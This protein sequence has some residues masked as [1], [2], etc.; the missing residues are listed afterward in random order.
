M[1]EPLRRPDD[2]ASRHLIE[3]AWN[4]PDLLMMLDFAG[5]ILVINPAWTDTLDRDAGSLVGQTFL[6]FVHVD[7]VERT[8]R[9]WDD[10]HDGVQVVDERNRWQDSNGVW[11]WLSWSLHRDVDARRVYAAGRDVTNM[12]TQFLRVTHDR[13]LLEAAE[14][15]AAVGS[16]EWDLGAGVVALS[17]E[18]RQLLHLNGDDEPIRAQRLLAQVHPDDRSTVFAQMEHARSGGVPVQF[19]F[20]IPDG[21]GS[22]RILLARAEPYHEDGHVAR[23]YGAVQ[24]ITDQRR[25]DRLKDAFLA[26]VSH[27]L[28]TPLTVVQGIAATLQRIESLNTATRRRLQDA[29]E[30]NVARLSELMTDL[31]DL[32]Q[33]G[34]EQMQFR[35]AV[36]DLVE[37][38]TEVA[39]AATDAARIVVEGPPQL[40]VVANR[41]MVERIL[42]NL[43]DNAGKYAPSGPVTVSIARLHRDGFQLTVADEG[44]GIPEPERE[45]IFQPFH[46]LADE[47][48]QPGTG[49]GLTLVA[50]FVQAHEGRVYARPRDG[51]AELVVEIP[52]TS[53]ITPPHRPRQ[54]S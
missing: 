3:L 54:G 52:G 1:M 7:D 35:P 32:A 53:E 39:S 6:D 11:R 43:L 26:A 34:R 22:D 19:E 29:L 9:R 25:V 40:Q 21:D 36:F 33:H 17:S 37:L 48:P 45:R 14:R 50:Q 13:Q 38:T 44:P 30:R 24:D 12:M 46:R 16:W 4:S 31:L 18:M 27:E 41:V 42:A 51:G 10:L 2:P 5:T 23:L 49:I 47:H 15:L 8:R 28:R 20:R